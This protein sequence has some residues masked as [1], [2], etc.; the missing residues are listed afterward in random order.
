MLAT[1]RLTYKGRMSKSDFTALSAHLAQSA[2]MK[3]IYDEPTFH[4]MVIQH[5]RDC[6]AVAEAIAQGHPKFD[7]ERF[8]TDCGV[9]HGQ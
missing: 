7:I 6:R 8:L 3:R 1:R 5:A 9:T 4:H 2:P